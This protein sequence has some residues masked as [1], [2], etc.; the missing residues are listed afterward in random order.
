MNE[1][2]KDFLI[3][4]VE[5]GEEIGRGGNGVFIRVAGKERL[6]RLRRWNFRNSRQRSRANEEKIYDRM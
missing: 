3:T 6:V 4:N 5:L 2:F 1:A